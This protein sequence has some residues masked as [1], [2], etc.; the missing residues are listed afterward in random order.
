MTLIGFFCFFVSPQAVLAGIGGGMAACVLPSR[1]RKHEFLLYCSI[2]ILILNIVNLI[3]LEFGQV[4]DI[5]SEEIQ[6][7]WGKEYDLLESEN[8]RRRLTFIYYINKYMN[9]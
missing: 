2:S 8:G 6:K 3:I 9:F 5:F 4:K 7:V 1:P